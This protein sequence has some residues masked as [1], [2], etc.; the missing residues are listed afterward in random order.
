MVRTPSAQKSHLPAPFFER[1]LDLV[2]GA[3]GKEFV[4]KFE[5]LKR[6]REQFLQDQWIKQEEEG[7]LLFR[8]VDY[9]YLITSLRKQQHV[10]DGTLIDVQIQMAETCFQFG[11]LEKS[12][13][14]LTN[15]HAKISPKQTT[16]LG[17]V[18]LLLGR[19]D[20]HRNYWNAS[21]QWLEQALAIYTALDDSEGIISAHVDLGILNAQRWD[22]SEAL[23]HFKTG[24]DLLDGQL[25][26]LLGLKIQNNLAIMDGMRGESGEAAEKFEQLLDHKFNTNPEQRTHLLINQGLAVK[27]TG[28]LTRAETILQDALKSAREIPSTRLIGV[29]SLGLAEVLIR[30]GSLESGQSYL[31]DAFKIFSQIHDRVS[32]ADTYRVFGILHRETGYLDLAAAKFDISIEM[33]R[34]TENLLNLTETY[35][36]YC[37]LAKAQK[38]IERQKRYLQ[39]S[40]SYAETMGA[41]PR[42]TKLQQELEAIA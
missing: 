3:L 27:E 24:Q 22:T 11:E 42:I 29:A 5:A 40:L 6:Q 2:S 13:D 23:Q 20:A 12:Y 1:L 38:D 32:L 33:N 21:R 36:E 19:A 15:L 31:I 18:C 35:H 7:E 30:N 26:N 10:K 8:E 25:D 34:E 16:Q 4:E 28:D 41:T 17:K 14:L 39:E 37:L 9:E